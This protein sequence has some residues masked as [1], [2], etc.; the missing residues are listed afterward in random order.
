M[1][2]PNVADEDCTTAVRTEPTRM[3]LTTPRNVPASNHSKASRN[4]ATWR[5]GLKP[6]FMS[7]RPKKTIP[8]PMKA[9][10]VKRRRSPLEKR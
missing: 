7:K 2:M 6:F 8:S 3:H 4:S 5:T 9:S 10:A 1:V